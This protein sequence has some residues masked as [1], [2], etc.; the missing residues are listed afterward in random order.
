VVGVTFRALP[1]FMGAAWRPRLVCFAH[2][3]PAS[4]AV[5]RRVFGRAVGFRHEFSGIVCNANDLDAPDPGTDPVMAR[6]TRR[7][8][9]KLPAR[10]MRVTDRVR[11][12]VALL[13]PRRHCRV[14]TVAQHLGVDR[15]TI[16]RRL[17]EEGRTFSAIVDGVRDEPLSRY[18][19]D[20][21]RPLTE[22]SA[23]LGF[24]E[25]S[26][27][28]RWHRKHFGVAARSRVASR[29]RLLTR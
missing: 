2:S 29:W 26:A 23:L 14:K 5:N 6:Y 16:A 1:I 12:F 4:L 3:A 20:G 11:E 18:R 28:S 19:A 7:R 17:V 10:S 21:G 24:S 22:A 13:L 27:F 8:V 15:R 9:D 25:P